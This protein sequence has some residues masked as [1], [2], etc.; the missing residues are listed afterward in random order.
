MKHWFPRVIV[1]AVGLV[2]AL[3]GQAHAVSIGDQFT[4]IFT[5]NFP[6]PDLVATANI[7]LGSGVGAFFSI[8]NFTAIGGDFCLTCGLTSQDL[9]N[10]SF[11]GATLGLTGYIRETF[12]GA[13]GENH[14]FTLAFTD[15]LP[16][17]VSADIP[18]G[19]PAELA[20]GAYAT[21]AV[22]EPST[23]LLLGSALAA[24]AAW[25]RRIKA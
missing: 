9:T 13:G 16:R 14:S 20:R 17:W 6:T 10:A 24:L 4:V 7:T 22:P 8:T 21:V 12:L 25:R 19:Q 1:I 3:T 15:L 5:E 2:I 23:A 18:D 11:D